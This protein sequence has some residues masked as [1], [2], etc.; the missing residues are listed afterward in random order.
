[1]IDIID[2]E[3]EV[4][5]NVNLYSEVIALA[6]LIGDRTFADLDFTEL[7]HNYNRTEI[8]NSWFTGT[9]VTYL[10]SNDSGFRDE[11]SICYPFVNWQ[12]KAVIADG[13]T[14]ANANMPQFESL[15]DI[16]RPFIQVKYL[17][18][19][20]FNQPNFPFS[21]T[22]AF[23]D[24]SEFKKLYMDFNWGSDAEPSPEQATLGTGYYYREDGDGI[25][26]AGD[27]AISDAAYNE[28]EISKNIPGIGSPLPDATYDWATNITTSNVD[29]N[30]YIVNF[31][32]GFTNT[33]FTGSSANDD[34]QLHCRWRKMSGA[35]Q[36]IVEDNGYAYI[37]AQSGGSDY[38]YQGTF[39]VE[40]DNLETLRLECMAFDSAGGTTTGA[41]VI[42]KASKLS[43][44]YP[45]A[46][47]QMSV[48]NVAVT[49]N[50]LLNS[51][52]GETGQW[53]FLKGIMTM[54]NLVTIPDKSD[55]SNI[56]IEPYTDVFINNTN[57]PSSLTLSARGI[58]HDWTDKIDQ[59]EIK[60]EILTELNKITKWQF[61]E[62][63][64]DA[65]FQGYKRASG[66]FLYGS[67]EW[68]AS[69]FGSLETLLSGEEEIIAEPFAATVISPLNTNFPDI[70]VPHVYAHNA[71][72]GTSEGFDNSPRIMYRADGSTGD[73]DSNGIKYL[74]TSSYFV[75][76]F[77]GVGSADLTS[78]LQ[79]SHLSGVPSNSLL[80]SD[81]HFG[82]CPLLNPVGFPPVKNLFNLYWLPYIAELYNPDTRILK[83]KV[84]LT[85][86]DI[87]TFN[88]YD[89]VFIK[90]RQYRVNSI[91]YKP[92]SLAVVE[93]ILIP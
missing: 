71:D 79:F 52:R 13:S 20:I 6:D 28:Y 37:V 50:T 8:Q 64:D 40:L 66:G 18:D 17:I 87:S 91:E 73:T 58:S 33:N 85:P 31:S 74:T 81:Y 75:P 24:T 48:S 16:F 43:T 3:G 2:K 26:P 44:G 5:Y 54:F 11:L 46:W 83:V 77:G 76:G 72:D 36:T 53:S 67:K 35:T 86:G 10:N 22:S 27:I 9:G 1:M 47:I 90:N 32:V 7:K 25:L 14:S 21:Y 30:T 60:L 42:Q 19:R 65:A 49:N 45:G 56:L 34:R 88:F 4:S 68:D 41:G 38:W 57:D 93:F 59:T 78:Y 62:D 80:S 12:D 69:T 92:N 51:L 55:P 23:F 89:T 15:T 29:G 39:S 84:N 82:E 61:A 70:L 63:E